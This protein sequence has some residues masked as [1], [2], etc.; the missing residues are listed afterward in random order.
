MKTFS[1]LK[2][3]PHKSLI[4]KR[5]CIYF[6]NGFGISVVQAKYIFGGF[7]SYTDNEEEY[8]IAVMKDGNLCYTTPITNDVIGHLSE[9]EVTEKMKLIQE[10]R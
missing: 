4:G 3:E 2:F 5:A 9:E 8:E 7:S 10:L 6:E 1:D